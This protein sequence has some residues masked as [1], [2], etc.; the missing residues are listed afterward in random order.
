MVQRIGGQLAPSIALGGHGHQLAVRA[1]SNAEHPYTVDQDDQQLWINSSIGVVTLTLEDPANATH[2][3][4]MIV[5]VDSTNTIT[6]TPT[7]GLIDGAASITITA[8]RIISCDGNEWR[9]ASDASAPA[10][11]TATIQRDVAG[12]VASDDFDRADGAIGADWTVNSA[13]APTIVSNELSTTPTGTDEDATLDASAGLDEMFVQ[14][15]CRS[16]NTS[17]P[18]GVLAKWDDAVG[19][20]M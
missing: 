8:S 18:L 2:Q 1:I 9:T 14:S 11:S 20:Y 15:F 5:V 16:G 7:V 6:L 4:L 19:G 12:L 3:I 10:A 13:N 17:V